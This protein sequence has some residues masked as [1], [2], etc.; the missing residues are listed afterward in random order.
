VAG[1]AA[2]LG[3]GAMTNSLEELEKTDCIFLIGSNPTENHPLVATRIYRA[4][5]RGAKLLIADPRLI[6]LSPLADLQVRQKL[7]TDIALLNGMMYVILQ[8]SWHDAQFIEKRTENFGEFEKVINKYPPERVAQITGVASK[9]IEKLAEYYACS[10]TAAIV[11]AMGITQHTTGVGNVLSLANLAML[12]GKI[13][14]ENTG[15]YP[16]RGQNNVQ[17]ACDMG[18]LPNFYPGYQPVTKE[19]IRKKFEEAW[20]VALPA[21]EGLTV[22][23]IFSAINEGKI[24][25]LVIMGENPVVSDPDSSHIELALRTIP[26]LTVIDI[27]MSHTA[28]FAEVVL[29]G[30]AFAEK[31]GTF[32]N[33]ER[34]VQRLMKAIE[35]PGKAKPEWQ[36]IQ[37]LANLFGY[38]MNYNSPREIME[39]IARLTP[40]YKGI[41]Y[42]RLA[43][44]GIFWPCPDAQHP[45][46]RILHRQQFTRG[47]G[48]FHAVEYQ[49]AAELPDA[50]YPFSLTTGRIFAQ[51]H[52]GTMTRISPSLRKEINECFVEINP[53][54]AQHLKI[55]QGEMVYLYSRRGG[56]KTRVLISERVGPGIVFMPFHFYESRANLLTNPVYDPVAKI[57]EYKVCAVRL[58]KIEGPHES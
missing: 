28:Q 54:D 32:T 27:F 49:P 7:G 41:S 23:E 39:E 15:I 56:V 33:T 25:A 4:K 17:G 21:Q 52:T 2:S 18:G 26:F 14:R 29:P 51:F 20:Q 8:K 12:T 36:I 57:P 45:G 43:G 5:E 40:A 35:P 48:R 46:T 38:K 31:D 3:S 13:G 44:P 58:S 24:K 50:E 1:L 10:P 53:A 55:S 47:K 42:D 34:R 19:E 37:E 11:Y 6:Q 22:S 9:D 30:A 16:L